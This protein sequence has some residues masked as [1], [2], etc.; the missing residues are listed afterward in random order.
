MSDEIPP[1]AAPVPPSPSLP[2]A[3]VDRARDATGFAFVGLGLA[4]ASWAARI[5]QVRDHLDLDSSALGL[6]LLCLAIGSVF[7]LPV[8]GHIVHRFGSRRTVAASAVLLGAALLLVAF[9]YLFGEAPVAAGLLVFGFANGT[10]DV[11]MNVHGALVE[12][13]LGRSA[14]SRFHAGYS[15]GTVAGALVGTAVVALHVPVTAHLAATGVVIAVGVPLAVRPMLSS[16]DAAEA[17]DAATGDTGNVSGTATEPTP[18]GTA[19]RPA[20]EA[21]AGPAEPGRSRSGVLAAWCEPRTLTVGLFVLAFAFAEGTGNDWISVALID[22]YHAP[23]AIGTLA[24]AVFLTAMTTGR[25]F[26]TSLLDRYGRVAVVR[27]LGVLATVGVLAFAF[28]PGTPVAFA[29]ALL[30]GVGASLGFPVGMSAAADDPARAA[31]RVSVVASIGYC[32]FLGGPP[33]IGFLA[34]AGSVRRAVLTVAA[35]LALAAVLAPALRP[36]RRATGV[37]SGTG[38]GAPLDP[39]ADPGSTDPAARPGARTE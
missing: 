23:A 24:F 14:M 13:L 19:A 27:V 9:G 15:L 18:A 1:S 32:A 30:W 39:F 36:L 16:A 5:P 33:L 11:A 29:G 37:A 22:G 12:R 2:A 26:G 25:W 8:S 20:A 4:A 17:V 6:L 28:G 21:A 35:L 34:H 38:P 3:E 10:W 7:A 31:A